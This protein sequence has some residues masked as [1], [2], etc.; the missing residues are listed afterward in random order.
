MGI[1]SLVRLKKE[2]QLLDSKM[3]VLKTF[4]AISLA[5][6]IGIMI[7]IVRKDMISVLFGLILTLEPVNT[8]GIKNGWNQI[9]ASFIGAISTALIIFAFGINFITV[10]LSVAITLYI[11]ILIDWKNISPVALFTAIYMTQNMQLGADGAPSIIKT[12][13]LRFFSLMFGVGMAI[14]VN[15]IFSVFQYRFLTNKRIVFV[16][17]RLLKDME[18]L[19]TDILS[20]E[21]KNFHNTRQDLI[22]TSNDIEWIASLFSDMAKDAITRAK[23]ANIG[24][25]EVKEKMEITNHLRVICHLLFDINYVLG[26]RIKDFD[27]LNEIYGYINDALHMVM[28]NLGVLK[29]LYEG[30]L[31]SPMLRHQWLVLPSRRFD[32]G[33][34][35]R[36]YQ[37][38]IDINKNLE[39]VVNLIKKES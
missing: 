24:M 39:A 6:I 30:E 10:G 8:T 15:F 26:D 7:P 16:M 1:F 19:K 32:N 11:C 37:N 23:I 36:I 14:L 18:R 9:T 13:E 12:I 34:A 4:I 22:V 28:D 21:K 33:Y 25:S 27:E 2:A 35:Y 3:F 20:R 5:Y 38:L 31:E 29:R 17:K